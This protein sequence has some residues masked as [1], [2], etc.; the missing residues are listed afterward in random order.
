MQTIT[1]NV[2]DMPLVIRTLD[3]FVLA[4]LSRQ[5]QPVFIDMTCPHRGGPLTHGKYEGESVL[6]PWHGNATRL[7]RLQRLDLPVASHGDRISVEIEG[8]IGFTRTQT[9]EN[10]NHDNNNKENNCDNE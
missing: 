4:R 1:F 6:C 2:T 9:E 5:S 3:R 10:C 8:F 7:C